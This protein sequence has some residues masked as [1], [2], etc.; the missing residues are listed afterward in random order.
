[1]SKTTLIDTE[2][3]TLSYISSKINFRGCQC[4]KDCS[5]AEDFKPFIHNCYEVKKKFNKPRKTEHQYLSEAIERIKML[6]TLPVNYFK[7]ECINQAKSNK[8]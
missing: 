6:E 7:P 2:L 4:F 1:M 3:Y 8:Q 5:C